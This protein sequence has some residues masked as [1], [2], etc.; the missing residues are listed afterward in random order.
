[1]EQALWEA[2]LEQCPAVDIRLLAE[3]II[4]HFRNCGKLL[5]YNL[6]IDCPTNDGGRLLRQQLSQHALF[7]NP[8]PCTD[9]TILQIVSNLKQDCVDS[10]RTLNTTLWLLHEVLVNE[11]THLNSSREAFK[12]QLVALRQ[13]PRLRATADP[14]VCEI[15]ASLD[16][17]IHAHKPGGAEHRVGEALSG[18]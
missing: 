2:V 7:R 9:D 6:V 13:L 1:M 18:F 11:S 17:L 3:Q 12:K 15:R 4:V 14:N 5:Y 16:F 10:I 8:K